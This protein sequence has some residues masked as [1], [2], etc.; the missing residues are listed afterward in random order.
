MIYDKLDQI[1]ATGAKVVLSRLPIGDLATQYFADKNIFCAGRVPQD[2]LERVCKATG[3][4][5]QTT[6]NGITDAVLGKC[7]KFEEKQLGNE[8]FNYFT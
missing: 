6:T 4:V 2:D 5:I 3:A 8:R 7:G 1:I